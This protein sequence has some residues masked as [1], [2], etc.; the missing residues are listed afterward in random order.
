MKVIIN[1]Y[2]GI[3]NLRVLPVGAPTPVPVC[4]YVRQAKIYAG[5]GLRLMKLLLD[6]HIFP[7][8]KM[9]NQYLLSQQGSTTAQLRS[10]CAP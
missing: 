6:P 7:L 8:I 5:S 9:L 10:I 4:L 3:S 1:L 2:N